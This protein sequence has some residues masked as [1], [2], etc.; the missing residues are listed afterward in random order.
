MI[1]WEYL[2]VLLCTNINNERLTMNKEIINGIIAI[3]EIIEA[4]NEQKDD[5]VEITPYMEEVCD[6]ISK[7]IEYNPDF[8]YAEGICNGNIS[9]SKKFATISSY[10]RSIGEIE[11]LM[12]TKLTNKY[13]TGK[14]SLPVFLDYT[15]P[16]QLLIESEESEDT[17]ALQI[18]ENLLLEWMEVNPDIHFRCADFVK[19][20]NFFSELY[21][22]I[23]QMKE[24]SGGIVYTRTSQ[25]G[26][27]LQLL[28]EKAIQS[29]SLR[30]NVQDMNDSF[31]GANQFVSII[32][33]KDSEYNES[34][35]NRLISLIDNARRTGL[36]FVLIG[37]RKISKQLKK[38]F[39]LYININSG[40][41]Y[42]NDCSMLQFVHE[43][44]IDPLNIRLKRIIKNKK[45]LD[46]VET[47]LSDLNDINA[48][49]Q[50]MDSTNVLRIPFASDKKGTL[51]FFE[52]GGE[53]PSHALISGSTGSGKSVA[54]HT[55]IMGI[56]YNYHPDDVEIWAIDYKAVEFDSYID[57]H[58]PHFR[59]IAHDS[60]IEF[61]LSL[62]DLLYEEYEDRMKKFLELGVKNISEYRAKCGVHSMPRIVVFID[63]FQIMTQA[64]QSYTGNKDYRT[65][66]ENLLRLTRAMGI[67][68][69]LCSQT[70]ASG[71]SGLTDSARDQ[72]GARLSLKHE[73]DNEIRETLMLWGTDHADINTNA[74]NLKRG[75]GIYRRM[76][77][78]HEET[79][80]GKSYD[81]KDV[82][83]YYLEESLKAQ[84]ISKVNSTI[85]TNYKSKNEIFVR[86]GGR[87]LIAEKV[88]HPI[89][90]YINGEVLEFEDEGVDWY[91]AAPTTLADDFHVRLEESAGANIL[92][93]GEND[94]LRESIVFHSICGFLMNPHTTVYVNVLDPNHSDRSRLLECIKSLESERLFIRE[95]CTSV[96]ELIK[97]FSKITPLYGENKVY[98]WYGLEKL[99]NE[100]F[101][102]TQEEE[103]KGNDL[104]IESQ[105]DRE[106]E[107]DDLLNFLSE[108][109]HDHTSEMQSGLDNCQIPTLE[110]C[111]K[112]LRQ[113]FEL[114]SENGYYHFVI[115]N[116]Y[117]NLKRSNVIELGNFENRIGSKMSIDDS[118]ELFNS[119]MAMNQADENTVI[120]YP[121][122][123]NVLPLRP[124]LMPDSEWIKRFN[125]IK[126]K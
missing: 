39:D 59:V 98:V 30:N 111:N 50:S 120:Y 123:G 28:E 3:S 74:K 14:V 19:N 21:G 75:E 124:Y 11:D 97:E 5:V 46:K 94:S 4:C 117:K 109:N 51:Q 33:L 110:E 89:M 10:T 61:S 32:Y 101:L 88:R 78:A 15:S 42:C 126:E 119:S 6:L 31:S 17:T 34:E 122:G 114:G 106:S 23:N 83:I 76:R 49:C 102:L 24:N 87:I 118:F 81:F 79:A 73:D 55:M 47:T 36:S 86:G 105:E 82:Y 103:E 22:M 18:V 62:L 27:L 93:V 104:Q 35:F 107:L 41:L 112:V 70:I 64:V 99:K 12:Q 95:G 54:L 80:D 25:F 71:L 1:E 29:L 72:I 125:S 53:A 52:I 26:D 67:S 69:I 58:T 121:G 91:P 37:R 100:L 66:L 63:E 77:L 115:F 90:K 113:T 45:E 108:L 40:N 44:P 85:G 38:V 60:S 16:V 20:G 65:I 56:I 43:P 96:L 116:N 57:K 84:I 9:N 92:L 8:Q 48:E 13:N 68:F 2:N 7:V